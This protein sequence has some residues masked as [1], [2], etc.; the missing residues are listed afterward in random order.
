MKIVDPGFFIEDEIDGKEMLKK[1]EQIGRVCYK[2]ECNV[3]D[4]SAV[5]FVR[6][7][8]KS[9]HESVIEHEK[10]TVRIICDRGV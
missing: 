5:R 7:I 9:G 3:T 10:V 8:I 6:N 1:I 4:D 2:S